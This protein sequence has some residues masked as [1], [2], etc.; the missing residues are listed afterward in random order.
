[1]SS[2]YQRMCDTSGSEW[3]EIDL[4][5]EQAK[6]LCRRL[7]ERGAGHMVTSE[8]PR[9]KRRVYFFSPTAREVFEQFVADQV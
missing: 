2:V 5:M 4:P 3:V 7:F 8:A 1:M 6:E 9:D